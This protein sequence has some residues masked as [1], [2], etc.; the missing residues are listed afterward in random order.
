[1]AKTFN[2]INKKV[3]DCKDLDELFE[4]WKEA[5][6]L[7]NNYECTT[8]DNI[9]KD[10]FNKDGFINQSKYENSKVKVL[11]ILK[12]SNI[13]K[14]KDKAGRP[15]EREQISW[16]HNYLTNGKTNP[17]KQHIKMGM[18]ACYINTGIAKK[19]NEQEIKNALEGSS[20]INLNKRGGGKKTDNKKFI[21]YVEKYSKFIKKQIELINPDIIVILGKNCNKIEK[22]ISNKIPFIEMWHTA[23]PMSRQDKSGNEYSDDK[24]LNCYFKHFIK[25]ADKMLSRI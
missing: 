24:N 3:D 25:Q 13:E 4:L 12:E 22:I 17:P 21:N 5:Q 15:T 6:S 2:E 20:F 23:Y 11:F 7:E 1:M 8:I 14:Y 9:E 16:Y 19:Y 10:S 18:M